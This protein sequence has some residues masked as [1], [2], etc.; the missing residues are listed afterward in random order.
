VIDNLLKIADNILIGGGMAYTFIKAGG[1][2]VG[3]S[4]V[5]D[6][7]IDYCSGVIKAAKAGKV[8]L[9]IAVDCVTADRYSNDANTRISDIGEIRDGWEGLDI[10]PKTIETFKSV[11]GKSGTVI[12][13]GP[14]G[15]S[16]MEKFANGTREICKAVAESDAVTIAGGGDIVY[17]VVRFG[18]GDK[19]THISTGGGASLELME[20]KTLPGVAALLNQGEEI[21]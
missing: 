1:G 19:F 17:A 13:N 3:N 12:W 20:G 21:I 10:G 8:N 14:L 18:F 4:I 11:I 5:D 9:Y 15:V 7:H 6:S 2:H 16:E